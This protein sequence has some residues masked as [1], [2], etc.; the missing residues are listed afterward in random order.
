MKWDLL[1]WV[2]R[3]EVLLLV[4]QNQ[5]EKNRQHEMNTGITQGSIRLMPN[6]V[7]DLNCL[8]PPEFWYYS[9]LRSCRMRGINCTSLSSP[10]RVNLALSA[11][12]QGATSQ[13][14]AEE[15]EFALS[16]ILRRV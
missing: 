6:I 9:I 2:K 12:Q 7:H 15:G 4:M 16:G 3:V 8:T 5:I 11:Y 10:D 13:G 1:F 14:M